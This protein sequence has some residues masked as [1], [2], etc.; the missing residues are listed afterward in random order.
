MK[1]NRP[2]L[3]AFLL[4]LLLNLLVV[5]AAHPFVVADK[6]TCAELEEAE[7]LVES[8]FE[9][10]EQGADEADLLTAFQPASHEACVIGPATFDWF[11]FVFSASCASPLAFGWRMPLR[12]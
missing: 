11:P 8:L 5:F 2:T 9:D 6:C 3:L 4:P 12:I 1:L 7:V 10:E